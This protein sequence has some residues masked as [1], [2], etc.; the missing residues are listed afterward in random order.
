[1]NQCTF[2]PPLPIVVAKLLVFIVLL[3]VG[4]SETVISI[5]NC[6]F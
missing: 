5:N 6:I 3:A 4:M 1:M 2:Q